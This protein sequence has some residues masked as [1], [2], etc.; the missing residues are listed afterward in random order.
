M[1]YDVPDAYMTIIIDL[2]ASGASLRWLNAAFG[3]QPTVRWK[4]AEGE[5]AMPVPSDTMRRLM[6]GAWIRFEDHDKDGDWYVLTDEP[7]RVRT[8]VYV[9]KQRR[10][11]P[12]GG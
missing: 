3:G 2:L 5:H 8:W 9:D 1:I 6:R 4:D 10:E 7:R 12:F 11:R